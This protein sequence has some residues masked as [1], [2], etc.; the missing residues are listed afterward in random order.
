[1]PVYSIKQSLLSERAARDI[2]PASSWEPDAK[3]AKLV[4][5]SMC[6]CFWRIC[7]HHCSGGKYLSSQWS[8]QYISSIAHIMNLWMTELELNE[9]PA[10]KG[11]PDTEEDDE[12][13]AGNNPNGRE[14]LWERQHA[15]AHDLGD[16]EH[17]NELP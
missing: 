9:N 2:C 10:G 14:C 17:S 16:H 8:K 7:S 15:I 13:Y 12:D 11:R 3:T 6:L 1:M 5:F 4:E